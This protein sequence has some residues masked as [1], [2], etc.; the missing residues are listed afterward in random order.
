[1]YTAILYNEDANSGKVA[2]RKMCFHL[3][4]SRFVRQHNN[5][6]MMIGVKELEIDYNQKQILKQTFNIY[7]YVSLNK[8]N[9][10]RIKWAYCCYVIIDIILHSPSICFIGDNPFEYGMFQ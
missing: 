4:V 9:R 10:N 6:N 5:E 7:I 3:E 8:W 1:M 2:V